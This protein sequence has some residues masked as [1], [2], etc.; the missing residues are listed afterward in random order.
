MCYLPQCYNNND[1]NIALLSY[2][3]AAAVLLQQKNKKNTAATKFGA[4]TLQEHWS[5]NNSGSCCVRTNH[6]F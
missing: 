6:L 2:N 5:N 1:L 4:I 3:I